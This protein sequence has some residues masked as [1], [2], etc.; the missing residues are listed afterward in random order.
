MVTPGHLE[1]LGVGNI[2]LISPNSSSPAFFD[3]RAPSFASK[4]S[5]RDT[6]MERKGNQNANF[7]TKVHRPML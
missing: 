7:A 2:Q 6:D 5:F 3:F 1:L 4:K